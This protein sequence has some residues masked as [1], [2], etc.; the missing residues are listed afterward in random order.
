MTHEPKLRQQLAHH[1]YLREQLAV[2]FP[3]ADE[4]TLCDTLEG[5]TN[6]TDMLAELI[7]SSLDDQAMVMTLKQRMADM[8]ERRT[9]FETRSQKKRDLACSVMER[10]DIQKIAEADLTV[11]LRASPPGLMV[12]DEKAIPA[13]YWIAQE[14]KLDRSGLRKMLQ[15]GTDVPGVTLGNTPLTISVRTK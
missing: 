12:T 7:R 4:E 5:M 2:Q 6:L 10:A 3:D 13:D 14:P 9:R 8:G 1:Q 11:S 15:N